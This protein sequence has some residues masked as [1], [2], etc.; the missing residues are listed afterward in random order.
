MM[1]TM[2]NYDQ[3]LQPFLTKLL[4]LVG[5]RNESE[6]KNEYIHTKHT[7]WNE[8]SSHIELLNRII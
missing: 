3:A 6:K 4:V 1:E 5:D 7:K 8:N 2:N